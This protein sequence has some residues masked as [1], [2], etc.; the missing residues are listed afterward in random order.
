[1]HST[2]DLMV[3]IQ[4]ERHILIEDV[5]AIEIDIDNLPLDAAGIVEPKTLHEGR[6]SIYFLAALA[7][8]EG[9]VTV[10]N[11]IEEKVL[12]PE[13]ETLR[14]KIN[15]RGL[16]NMGLSARV[17][18]HMKDG[19]IHE[20]STPAP[21]GSSAKPLSTEEVIEKFK[22]TSSLSP[23]VTGEIIEQVM[24]LDGLPSINEIISLI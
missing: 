10:D 4:K 22:S 11:L 9:R 15:V 16:S 14:K 13:L 17:K 12:D 5:M 19:T 18:V 1:M 7:L 2:V 8:A 6:F 23:V 21:K 20:K 24:G 3:E